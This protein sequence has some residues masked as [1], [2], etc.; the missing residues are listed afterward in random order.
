MGVSVS[1]RS[2]VLRTIYAACLVLATPIHVLFDVRYGPLLAGLEP[3]GYPSVV[4][5]YWAALTFLDPLG[6]VL[7]FVRPRAGL[8]LCTVIIVTD[9]LNNSWVLYQRS[10]SAFDINYLLQ[11]AFLVF[12]LA[13]VRSAWEGVSKGTT[14]WTQQA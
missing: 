11:V 3:L 1:K 8:V 9:V 14:S 5:L 12:V 10:E 4:R 2:L 6:A 13:T 7:L